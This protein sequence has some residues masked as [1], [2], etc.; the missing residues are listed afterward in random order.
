MTRFHHS[1]LLLFAL[2]PV[3]TAPGAMAQGFSIDGNRWYEIEVSIFSNQGPQRSNELVI[4]EK[5]DLSYQQPLR[6]LEPA[7]SSFLIDFDEPGDDATDFTAEDQGI[8]SLLQPQA[9][10][11]IGPEPRPPESDFRLTDFSR[12]PFIALG[13]EEA[14]F[15]AYNRD[16]VRSPDHRL[17]FHAVWRQP[18]LNR[19]QSGAIVVRGGD[20][21]GRH[22]ELEGSLRFSYNINRVDIEARLWLATFSAFPSAAANTPRWQLPDP[23]F[24][25]ADSTLTLD[26]PVTRLAYMDQ[27]RQMVSNQ[28]YYLDHPDMG[29]L[30]QIRP[31]TLPEPVGFSFE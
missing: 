5:I 13:E 31:Y 27:L 4:P 22:H 3:A 18:V 9:P 23:P 10:V 11:M 17:L 6:Q 1:C 7:V 25:S 15:T 14:E 19:V 30:V 12:D 28:L 29:I 16:L 2:L 26:L 24:P 8:L 21:Y 20:Q